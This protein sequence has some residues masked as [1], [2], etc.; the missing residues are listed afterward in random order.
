MVVIG[1]VGNFVFN[2]VVVDYVEYYI[3][4]VF[5]FGFDDFDEIFS[6]VVD[7]VCGFE[8][9]IGFVFVGVVCGGEYVVI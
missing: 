4:V 1:G 8:V 9:D 6:F 2:I 7:G 5:C 3:G